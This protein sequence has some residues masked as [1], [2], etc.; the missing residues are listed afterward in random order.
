MDQDEPCRRALEI[1]IE[2]I[3]TRYY[4]VYDRDS[5]IFYWVWNL[6]RIIS[7]AFG[8]IGSILTAYYNRTNS[9]NE[10]LLFLGI[11]FPSVASIAGIILSRNRILEQFLAWEKGR[12]EFDRIIADGKRKLAAARNEDECTEIHKDLIESTTKAD[13]LYTDNWI[14][15][16]L[17]KK[18]GSKMDIHG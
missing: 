10:L 17:S 15:L 5:I 3:Y 9:S 1:Y 14:R 6:L 12:L 11:A 2:D 13:E 18:G 4:K 8:F 7:I 16:F